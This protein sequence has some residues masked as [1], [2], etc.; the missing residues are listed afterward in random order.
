MDAFRPTDGRSVRRIALVVPPSGSAPILRD[1]YCTSRSKGHYYW[2][3]TD[4]WAQGALLAPH[5]D[6]QLFDAGAAADAAGWATRI[7]GWA[8]DLLVGLVGGFSRAYDLAFLGGLASELGV[9]LVIGGESVWQAGTV[10]DWP[11]EA[12]GWLT[13]FVG[14]GLRDALLEA[15]VSWGFADVLPGGA[16][17]IPVPGFRLGRPPDWSLA[18]YRYPFMGRPIASVLTAYGCPFR[19]TYCNNN[20]DL[21]G[22]GE[23]DEDDL[24]AELDE[25]RRRGLCWLHVRDVNF[26]GRPARARRLLETWIRRGY[27][28]RWNAWLRPELVDE[29]LVGLLKRAG[30]VQVQMGVESADDGVLRGLRRGNGHAAVTRAFHLLDRAGI[31]RGAH[32]VL[33]LPGEDEFAVERT[34]ERARELDPDYASFNLGVVRAGTG[35]AAGPPGDCTEAASESLLGGIALA[36]LHRLRA[37]AVRRLYLRPAYLRRLLRQGL[38]DPARLAGALPYAVRLLKQAAFRT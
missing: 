29:D 26:G 33:G 20:R 10:D 8:P 31:R 1:Y 16:R 2:P 27:R 24:F 18:P 12:V 25:W 19:C 34:I 5:F 14:P 38:A 28:F 15:P 13:A 30:C 11:P 21:M 36:D 37:R 3:P 17:S 32:F 7:R 23:R 35:L 6:L 22:L 9:R 4:L